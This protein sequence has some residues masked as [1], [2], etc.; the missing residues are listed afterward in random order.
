MPAPLDRRAALPALALALGLVV[1][2]CSDDE[3]VST[4]SAPAQ[5][6]ETDD[7]AT[8]SASEPASESATPAAPDDE[9]EAGLRAIATAEAE[10]GGIAYGVDRSRLG[11]SWEVDVAV[12]DASVE[13]EL[14][15]T[16][17]AVVRT[18]DDDLD[19]DEREALDGAQVTLA[20]AVEAVVDEAGG[21]IDDA[22]L[23]DDGGFH[24]SVSVDVDGR[25]AD[26][27]V[28]LASGEVTPETDD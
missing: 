6:S 3:P 2:G 22:G 10:A 13:I 18:Q 16:G 14:D 11:T 12:G 7:G 1:T 26:Y 17:T 21:V 19:R 24:W 9:N 23:E 4:P 28:D 25:D 8:T 15:A 27:A 20:Q 5:A